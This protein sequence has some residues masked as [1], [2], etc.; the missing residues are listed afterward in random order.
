VVAPPIGVHVLQPM[1]RVER[2][3]EP[4]AASDTAGGPFA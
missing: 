3:A 2:S 1:P 4:A